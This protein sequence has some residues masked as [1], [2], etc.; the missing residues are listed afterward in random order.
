MDGR[1]SSVPLPSVAIAIPAY[2]EADSIAEFLLEIDEALRGR[3][4]G[5][6]LV[7]VDDQST[8]GTSEAVAGVAEKLAGDVVVVRNE[9]NQGHGPTVLEAYRR[10]LDT[11][12]DLILQVDGDGQFLGSD[13]RRLM[14]LLEDGAHAVCGV[15]RFRYDP[16]FRMAMTRLVRI[17]LSFGFGVPTRDANCPLR[18]YRS[19]SLDELL[20]WV[21][22]R[23]LVPNLYLT[24]LSPRHGVTMV[25][26]DVNHRVRRGDS[27]TGSTWAGATRTTIARRLLAF[28][29]RALRES[30]EFRRIANSGR[31]PVVSAR[32]Q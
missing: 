29:A 19:A 25:E 2:N 8:D 12:A 13:L 22:D 9:V 4:S 28:S 1:L 20:R 10:A 32:G 26:V 15:R 30:L 5:L 23:A 16:W 14:V 21:P 7:V 3:T 27:T 24:I 11:G 6:T 31:P 18:G 17:Y